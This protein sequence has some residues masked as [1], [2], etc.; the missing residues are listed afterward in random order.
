M[1][2][3]FSNNFW[4]G[5]FIRY[6]PLILWVAV[7]FAA[8]S[9]A[10]ASGNTSMFI[11]P[12]LEWLFPGATP[13]ALDIYHGYIRKLAH[14]TEYAVLGFIAAR[15]FRFSSVQFVKRFWFLPAF[16]V[17]AAIASADEFNQSFNNLRT[18]SIYDVMID[19]AGGAT[20]IATILFWN[21]LQGRAVNH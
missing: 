7:I 18:G 21:R 13:G 9:S 15:A 6:A 17:V 5:R 2:T 10:G 16:A 1:A 11:R 12:L 20:M 14:F 19:C 8:S 4:R 3:Q